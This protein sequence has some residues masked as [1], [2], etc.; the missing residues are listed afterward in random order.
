M[1]R[2][3]VFEHSEPMFALVSDEDMP[4]VHTLVDDFDDRVELIPIARDV[5]AATAAELVGLPV[6]LIG[7]LEDEVAQYGAFCSGNL[8]E[9][10]EVRRTNDEP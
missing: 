3:D 1:N 10:F 9:S 2:Y 7:R 6:C 4:Y 5:T 8:Q